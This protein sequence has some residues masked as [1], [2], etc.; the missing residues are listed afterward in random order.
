MEENSLAISIDSAGVR[1]LADHQANWREF[2]LTSQMSVTDQ[3]E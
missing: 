2:E 3:E 1:W